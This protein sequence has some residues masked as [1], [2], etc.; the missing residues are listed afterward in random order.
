M[1]YDK[2]IVMK[3]AIIADIHDNLPNLQTCIDQC[4]K[5][6]IENIICCGDVT[7]KETLQLMSENFPG[8]I[9]L[10]RG[11]VEIFED[12]DLEECLNI[13]C[14]G[15]VGSWEIDGKIA[16]ACHEP[17]LIDKV[18][19]KWSCEI[20]FYGHTHKPWEEE[21]GGTRIINPGTLGGV[22][23]RPT[24][25]VWDTQTGEMELKFVG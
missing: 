21:R 5:S 2:V 15:R 18:L 25:A 8:K 13:E 19:E 23:Y 6:G 12:E 10:V 4:K 7:N 11:N 1:F 14:G 20:V 24:Y 9:M 3:V 16:G 22:F 17:F